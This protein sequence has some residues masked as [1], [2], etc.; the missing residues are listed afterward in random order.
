MNLIPHLQANHGDT[1]EGNILVFELH[2]SALNH[3]SQNKTTI[4]AATMFKL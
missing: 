2:E 4:E 3:S 1:R